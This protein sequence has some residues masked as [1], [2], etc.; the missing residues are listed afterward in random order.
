MRQ[1]QIVIVSF[2]VLCTGNAGIFISSE[3]IPWRLFR[4]SD[5]LAA[6]FVH[7]E[8][9]AAKTATFPNVPPLTHVQIVHS[10]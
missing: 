2:G 9:A 8:A 10:G 3:L 6:F 7:F 1:P 4:H 5:G